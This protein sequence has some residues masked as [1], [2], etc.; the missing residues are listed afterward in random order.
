MIVLHEFGSPI[1]HRV[2]E[3][4]GRIERGDLAGKVLTNSEVLGTPPYRLVRPD[5]T[6]G[7]ATHSLLTSPLRSEQMYLD[8]TRE[9][10]ASLNGRTDL[11]A[12]FNASHRSR[13]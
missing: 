6:G 8:A 1:E 7:Y 12:L 5:Q 2:L 3:I 10:K 4:L 11:H 13:L 9:V